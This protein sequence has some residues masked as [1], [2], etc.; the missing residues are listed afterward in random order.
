MCRPGVLDGP[1]LDNVGRQSDRVRKRAP[2]AFAAIH[3]FADR[4]I[5]AK[6]PLELADV[7]DARVQIDVRQIQPFEH[8]AVL[9]VVFLMGTMATATTRLDHRKFAEP[10]FAIKV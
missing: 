10:D 9:L 2:Q 8:L 1:L 3:H 7:A 6:L 4:A 5:I